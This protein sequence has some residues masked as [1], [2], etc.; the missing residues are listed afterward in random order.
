MIGERRS[1]RVPRV[2][3][4]SVTQPLEKL[5][6]GDDVAVDEHHVAPPS[7]LEAFVD[8]PHEALIDGVAQHDDT[9]GD[10]AQLIGE[11]GDAYVRACVVDEQ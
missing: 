10:I 1:G 11:R 3:V 8:G 9:R 5:G 4:C 2:G 6:A 7:S